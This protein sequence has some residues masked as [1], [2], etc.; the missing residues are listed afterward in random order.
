MRDID[1]II[2]GVAMTIMT[3]VIMAIA[4]PKI[5][6]YSQDIAIICG[7]AC[8]LMILDFFLSKELVKISEKAII[9]IL[10]PNC[11][12]FFAQ[13]RPELLQVNIFIIY[14]FVV[15]NIIMSYVYDKLSQRLLKKN[16][17]KLDRSY[18]KSLL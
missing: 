1:R 16:L 2:K 5:A 17:S 15:I 4:L 10:V 14:S 12:M 9:L 13:F 3:I 11:V 7:C 8:V 6:V 18:F